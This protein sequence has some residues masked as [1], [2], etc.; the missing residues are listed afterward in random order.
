MSD[1]SRHL[2]DIAWATE[3]WIAEKPTHLIH[4]DGVR[5]LGPYDEKTINQTAEHSESGGG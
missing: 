4:F 1:M 3:V 5:F 2:S